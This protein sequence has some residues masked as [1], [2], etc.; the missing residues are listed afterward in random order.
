MISNLDLINH[1][2]MGSIDVAPRYPYVNILLLVI[3]IILH[4]Y[5]IPHMLIIKFKYSYEMD[6]TS[7]TNINLSSPININ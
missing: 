2:S 5:K 1:D 6:S 7:F 3:C 4:V